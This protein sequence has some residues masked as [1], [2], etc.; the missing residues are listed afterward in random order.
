MD[1]VPPDIHQR[2]PN[3][4]DPVAI[5]DRVRG[6][7]P[8]VHQHLLQL[9]RLAENLQPRVQDLRPQVERSGESGGGSVNQ[10]PPVFE[11]VPHHVAVEVAAG[12]EEDAAGG[13]FGQA[14]GEANVLF[15]LRPARQEK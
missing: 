9:R 13:A 11:V 5:A 10:L 12:G 6:V 2:L 15:G 8:Q 7:R 3:L 4:D 14:G 1:G